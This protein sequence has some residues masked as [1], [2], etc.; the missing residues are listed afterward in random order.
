MRTCILR[1]VTS[2]YSDV[3]DSSLSL[4]ML[5]NEYLNRKKLAVILIAGNVFI[6]HYICHEK[7]LPEFEVCFYL[8]VHTCTCICIIIYEREWVI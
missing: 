7:V 6:M 3:T 2:F 5:S 1:R 4:R 8:L